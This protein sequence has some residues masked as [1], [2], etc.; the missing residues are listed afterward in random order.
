VLVSFEVFDRVITLYRYNPLSKSAS[1]PS[2]LC[3]ET[4]RCHRWKPPW[5]PESASRSKFWFTTPLC[6]IVS[7]H[8]FQV[9]L[10]APHKSQSAVTSSIIVP[11]SA[12]SYTGL[13][14]WPLYA[15]SSRA[16]SV[17]DG[18]EISAF[19]RLR[20]GGESRL[21]SSA[22]AKREVFFIYTKC[23]PP[24]RDSST[25]WQCHIVRMLYFRSEIPTVRGVNGRM[26]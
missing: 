9:A 11:L 21:A 3:C 24:S 10:P 26:V 17:E 8:V 6:D 22:R 25:C 14:F 7:G 15:R 5:F 16:V 12:R 2:P 18:V 20:G 23:V 19:L 13:P 4:L 1:D